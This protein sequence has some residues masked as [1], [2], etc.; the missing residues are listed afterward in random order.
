MN[1]YQKL[2]CGALLTITDDDWYIE[3]RFLP[4]EPKAELITF[5]IDSNEV[6]NHLIALKK[7]LEIFK[8]Y[9]D[10]SDEGVYGIPGAMNM[11]INLHG[12]SKGVCILGYYRPVRNDEEYN[13]IKKSF[14]YAKKEA[15]SM[16]HHN[17]TNNESN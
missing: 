2:P 15:N 1:Y 11:T 13:I 7:N 14:E 10:S 4:L 5:R 6:D 8:A 9:A 17:T 3:Y 12:H 16:L